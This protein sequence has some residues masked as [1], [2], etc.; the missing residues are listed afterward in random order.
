MS[1]DHPKRETLTLEAE[2]IRNICE[3]MILKRSASPAKS[4]CLR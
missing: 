1:N 3:P 4:A 2:P